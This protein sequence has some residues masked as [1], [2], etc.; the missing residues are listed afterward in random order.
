MSQKATGS[1]Q[2]RGGGGVNVKVAGRGRKGATACRRRQA[3]QR[4]AVGKR[5]AAGM[6]EGVASTGSGR[7][8]Q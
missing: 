6:G 8:R 4:G 2:V 7:W 3:H 5:R 1:V